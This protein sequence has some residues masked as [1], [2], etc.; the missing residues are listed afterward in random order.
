MNKTVECILVTLLIINGI[1]IGRRP[2]VYDIIFLSLLA[3]FLLIIL[4]LY[5][6]LK[7][8]LDDTHL[9]VE[10]IEE[11]IKEIENNENLSESIK[12][13]SI[14]SLRKKMNLINRKH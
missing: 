13:D 11:G 8:K 1:L 4:I 2:A 3:L 5:I 7:K 14:N 6:I 12:K 9:S 10:E